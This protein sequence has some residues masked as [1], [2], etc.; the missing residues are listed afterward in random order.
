MFFAQDRI[1]EKLT[2]DFAPQNVSEN[3][4]LHPKIIGKM[5]RDGF[6]GG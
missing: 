4:D 6:P 2:G 1:E 5:N 3:Q